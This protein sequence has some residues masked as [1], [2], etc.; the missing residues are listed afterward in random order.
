MSGRWIIIIIGAIIELCL[1]AVHAYSVLSVPL[2]KIFTDPI[3]AGGFGLKV[4]AI[5]MQMPYIVSLGIFA[6]TMPLAGKYI[7]T[8]GP[9]KVG[10]IGGFFVGLGW[11]LASFATS[12]ISLAV[13]YG[14][15]AGVGIGFTHGCLMTTS[16][17]WF[18]D[19]SGL[20]VGLTILGF[21]FSAFVTGKVADMLTASV[22]I[23]NAFRFIGVGL[24]ILVVVLSMFLVL[25]PAGWCPAGRR[26]PA[27][28]EGIVKAEFTR[29]EMMKTSSFSALWVCYTI[30]ALAGLMAIGIAKPAGLEVTVKA[31]MD[32]TY[33]GMLMTNLILPFAFCNAVGRP[34]F[35]TLADTFTPQ[36]AAILAYVLTIAASLLIYT[37]PAS[38]QM[39]TIS[40]SLLWLS[41]GGW[42]AI[43]PAATASYFG[44]KD[45]ARNNGMLFTGYGVGAIVGNLMAGAAKD[46][47]GGYVNVF[48]FVAVLS[49]LGI[50]VVFVLLKPPVADTSKTAT[51]IRTKKDPLKYLYHWL[52]F[53]YLTNLNKQ[54]YRGE[55]KMETR[56]C[57][58]NCKTS[59]QETEQAFKQMKCCITKMQLMEKAKSINAC[60]EVVLAVENMPEKEYYNTGDVVKTF[61]CIETSLK[62]LCDMEFPANKMKIIENCKKLHCDSE[63]MKALNACVDREYMNC[64]DVMMEC[65]GKMYF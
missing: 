64:S 38:V 20:A 42:L 62:A 26:S 29:K 58:T 3:S 24:L 9:K 21:G 34:L 1:G 43:G 45:Y 63:I 7:E 37:N 25:P 49:V 48:P 17:K 32:A 36:I 11:I 65:K 12:P 61:S 5:M 16:A 51:T 53:S 2:N 39:Y 40:F 27:A 23:F 44:T 47:L 54:Q 18:P 46:M 41:F 50:I 31:G 6:I 56:S 33:A 30:G 8:M 60:R 35:G 52:S 14:F 10:I 15:V 22:G 28:A 55:N 57:S 4:S 59:M 19:K 13:L